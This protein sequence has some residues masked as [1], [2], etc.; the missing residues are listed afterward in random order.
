MSIQWYG[1]VDLN[2][3]GV[4]SADFPAR[5]HETLIEDLKSEIDC[6]ER[7]ID[8]DVYQGKKKQQMRDILKERKDRYEA[9]MESKPKLNDVE[10]DKVAKAVRSL[11][12]KVGALMF[13]RE[14]M[15]Q[16]TVDAH[17][18]A[19]RWQTPCVKVESEYEA[20]FYKQKGVPIVNGMV[21]RVQAEIAYKVMLKDLESGIVPN[22]E[23]LRLAK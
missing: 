21:N 7:D 18:E 1:E 20:D 23:R 11:G 2:K 16:R 15:K 19:R 14:E 9:I 22:T 8:L 4:P 3:K 6:I 5:Y 17:E 13:T 12:N 10:R